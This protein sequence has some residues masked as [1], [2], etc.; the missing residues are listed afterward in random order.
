MTLP[1]PQQRL[2]HPPGYHTVASAAPRWDAPVRVLRC[3]PPYQV[4]PLSPMFKQMELD[5]SPPHSAPAAVQPTTAEDLLNNVMGSTRSPG[6]P[7]HARGAPGPPVN[8]LFGAGGLTN[9]I[10][11]PSVDNSTT[12]TRSNAPLGNG[13]T[14]PSQSTHSQPLAPSMPLP[15]TQSSLASSQPWHALPKTTTTLPSH[16]NGNISIPFVQQQAFATSH[17]RIPSDSL[18]GFRSPTLVQ[19]PL[20]DSL[21]SSI[22]SAGTIGEPMDMSHSGLVG[23]GPTSGFGGTYSPPTASG[24][25]YRQA[26][27]DMFTVTHPSNH[28]RREQAF[29][30]PFQTSSISNIWGTPG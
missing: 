30:S 7:P 6:L 28:L 22:Y 16:L 12:Y 8:L 13:R 21:N 4:D 11:S 15:P 29:H 5:R 23:R 2:W 9:S 25:Y 26:Q 19:Q 3:A 1:H 10:W 24:G 14:Y 17:Q 27:P 20:Y 18:G